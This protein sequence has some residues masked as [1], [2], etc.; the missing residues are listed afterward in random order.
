[1]PNRLAGE[2][3]PYLVQH[4]GNPVDWYPWGDEALARA[5]ELDRPILLSIGY[6]ACHWCHVMAHESFED[7]ATA[8]LMNEHFVCIKVDR[9]ERPDLDAIYMQAVQAMTGHGG[10]PMTVFLTPEGEPFYGGTY[11]PPVDRHGMP[12]FGRILAAVAE[13]YANRRES[14]ASSAASMRAI[15]EAASSR[16]GARAVVNE[17][18]L[19]RCAQAIES[20]YDPVHGGFGA[21]PKFPPTMVLDFLLRHWARTGHAR[22]LDIAKNTF[23][24]MARGGIHDQAGGGFARY[25]VDAM[26]LVPH[27]E[28]MLYDNALLIRFGAHLYEATHDHEVR[29]VTQR[30]VEWLSREMTS[31][32]GGFQSSLDADS[33]GVEGK[34]YV[35]TPDELDAVLGDDSELIK[36]YF[37]VTEGGNFE[38]KN[39]LHSG[40]GPDEFATRSRIHADSFFELLDRSTAAL[41]ARRAERVWPGLD[42]KILASWN[43]LALRGIVEAARA[44]D[45]DDFRNLGVRN[46]EFLAKRLVANGRAWRTYKDGNARIPGFLEDQAAVALGFLALFEQTLDVRWLDLARLMANVMLDMFHDEVTN[47]FHDTARDAEQLVTR[48]RDPSDNAIPSGTS[49]AVDL[50]LRLSTYDGNDKF[51]TIAL[52]VIESVGEMISR[53]P[54][55][56]GHMLGDAEYAVTFACHGEYCDMPSPRALELA[57]HGLSPT[58]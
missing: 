6:A 57:R 36:A 53:Y 20:G 50:L 52:G 42:D 35:W 44:F 25:S 22:A 54:S 31:P 55:A 5:R 18:F 30:T 38:G 24:H 19:D 28:K 8:A 26:W 11:F 23:L 17:E 7:P 40:A 1:M 29:R 12:S 15:Y 13:S 49:L 37:G 10:W 48:P 58:S 34:F 47:I 33:E 39:I 2:T 43:G 56:F 27:F 45:R 21:A 46:G 14:I 3:S 9:E 4:S 16:E 41:Y 32:E 51:R